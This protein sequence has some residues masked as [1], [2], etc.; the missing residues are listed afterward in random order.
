MKYLQLVRWPNLLIIFASMLLVRFMLIAP[1]L[2]KTDTE[3]ATP[4]LTFII[5]VLG[6]ILIAAGGFVINDL[7]DSDVDSINKA[8][9]QLIGKK[10]RHDNAYKLYWLLTIGGVLAG[11][12]I[13]F[14]VQSWRI[15]LIFFMM[16]GLMWFYSK[17][18]KRMILVGNIVVSFASAMVF[19]IVWLVE[20]F[21]LQT[22]PYTFTQASVVFPQ[23]TGL[24]M[25][26]TLFALLTSM[27]RE[28]AKD[29]EDIT[30]D[31]RFGCR[32]FP[33]VYGESASKNTLIGLLAILIVMIIFWQ[34]I[35]YTLGYHLSFMFLF[36]SDFLAIS[37][38][39][40][41]VTANSKKHY[42]QTSSILKMLIISGLLSIL[43]L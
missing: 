8:D 39:A 5:L 4:L 31:Q 35:L 43:F 16:T 27:I 34:Y 10:I 29:V 21:A 2:Q 30:G 15:S 11:I 18:Y 3:L 37:V 13:G 14:A 33:V 19:V 9:K 32:T 26:Y 24:V 1:Q 38:I 36:I 41:I 25:A 28:L 17:R 6:V 20:F 23:I 42:K 40:R 22:D 12:Y 7:F